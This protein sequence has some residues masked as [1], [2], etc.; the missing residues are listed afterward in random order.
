MTPESP[1]AAP[2]AEG[3]TLTVLPADAAEHPAVAL[4]RMG[5]RLPDQAWPY[6]TAEGAI[7]HYVLRWNESDGSKEIR[8]LSWV[9]S[10][11]GE[12]WSFKAWRDN[13]LLYN[14]DKIA[15]NPG[16]LIIVCEGE[17]A[18][19]AILASRI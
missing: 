16:A 10:A 1:G 18:A 12:G 8:P 11:N 14:L 4:K 6:R 2:A 15:A 17:K 7:S 9:Q 19:D 3:E 5:C 13:R